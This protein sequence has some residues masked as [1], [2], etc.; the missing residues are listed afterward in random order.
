MVAGTGPDLPAQSPRS[1][2]P[3][4]ATPS[5]TKWS[6]PKEDDLSAILAGLLFGLVALF[7][8]ATR[9]RLSWIVVGAGAVFA[10][11][12]FAAQRSWKLP[13]WITRRLRRATR[14]ERTG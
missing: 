12:A 7:L 10:L 2:P 6:R 8:L 1:T 11:I 13:S 5:A 4:S 14:S 9:S 3:I